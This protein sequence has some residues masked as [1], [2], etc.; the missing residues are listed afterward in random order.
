VADPVVS[1]VVPV[2]N[3][4]PWLA[5][6]LASVAGQTLGVE[7]I[8]L[9]AVD[10]GSTD[11]SGPLLDEFAAANPWVTVIHQANSGGPGSPRN[12][13]MDA[14]TGEYLFFLDAD[15]Y[16]GPEALERLVAMA[17][18]N[19]SDIV[20]GRSVG[21]EG[22]RVYRDG[23]LFARN[24]DRAELT[25]VSGSTSVLKLFRRSLLGRAGLRFTAGVPGGED[26]GFMARAYMAAGRISVLA[27]YPCYYVRRR[28]GSQTTRT[29]RR[30]DLGETLERI[31]T[32]RI[33]PVA[34]GRRLA[35]ERD[36][37]VARHLSLLSRKFGRRWLALDPDERERVFRIGARIVQRWS[38]PITG[39]VLRGRAALVVHCLAHGLQAELGDVV[40]C[41][42]AVA[43]GGAFADGGRIYA[44]Y[45]HFRDASGI[46]DAC[47]DI[48]RFVT[49]EQSLRRATLVGNRLGLEGEA[50]LRL[51]GGSVAIELRRWPR[52]PVHRLTPTP[53][54]TPALR[55]ADTTY[56]L[57][58]YAA[59][60]DLGSVAD[61]GRLAGGSWSI[62]LSVG[63][64]EVRRCA[65]LAAPR[66]VPVDR[67]V[68][69]SPGAD[70]RLRVR[71]DRTIRLQVGRA[72]RV[73]TALELAEAARILLSRGIA[74]ALVRVLDLT[75]VG[76]LVVVLRPGVADQAVD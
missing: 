33:R 50:Y 61:G 43:F 1:V 11:R 74:R 49:V 76:R 3:V 18:R 5:E 7:R 47:F 38:T 26:G 41:P 66:R 28:P 20:I 39:R 15:D 73:V 4:E 60:I 35:I 13:G 57:A 30:D 19:G 36:V 62:W 69:M 40:A 17:E 37:L 24:V 27:D 46:P 56:P 8:R 72:S 51:V 59:S 53:L 68:D 10:D 21:V 64:D 55:D 44:R 31:E 25:L 16:L 54:P 29:D 34:A 75:R 70:N 22:R 65:A 14:A 52:G 12:T 67:V 48:T 2:W 32:E 42:R 71:P 45:P 23:R 58:G 9:I 6:C 63:T